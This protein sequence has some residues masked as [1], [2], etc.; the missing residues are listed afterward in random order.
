MPIRDLTK[1][2][3]VYKMKLKT[4]SLKLHQDYIASGD[5]DLETARSPDDVFEVL[6]SIFLNLDDDQEHLI[7]LVLNQTK[8]LTGFKLI[9]SGGQYSSL[10]D[11]KI[12]FRNALLLGAASIIVAHNH[13]AGSIEPSQADLALTKKIVQAGKALDIELVDH[14][15]FTPNKYCSLMALNPELFSA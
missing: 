13:P 12:L 11:C 10:V 7:L 5:I 9:A 15:I 4:V 14:I 2:D 1:V 8:N 3:T 6:K